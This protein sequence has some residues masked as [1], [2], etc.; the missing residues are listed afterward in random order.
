MGWEILNGCTEG[1]WEGEFTYIGARGTSVIDYVITSENISNRISSFRIGNRVDSDH[2]P[3]EL[4]I[5]MRRRN[6]QERKTSSREERNKKER[7]I[8]LW[9]QEAKELFAE[10]AE[11]LCRTECEARKEVET[12]EEKWDRIKHIVHGSMERKR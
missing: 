5:Q 4:T 1:D 11:E 12:I 10:K 9:N 8:I 6:R 3:L 2:M 7:E